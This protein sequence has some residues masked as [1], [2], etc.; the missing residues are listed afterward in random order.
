M[1]FLQD[2]ISI[3]IIYSSP[4]KQLAPNKKIIT[5]GALQQLLSVSNYYKLNLLIIL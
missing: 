2:I 5:F 4:K 3:P 1:F